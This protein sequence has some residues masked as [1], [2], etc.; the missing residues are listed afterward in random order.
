LHQATI[1]SEETGRLLSKIV[2]EEIEPVIQ[3]LSRALLQ[4]RGSRSELDTCLTK[5]E[6]ALN[7]MKTAQQALENSVGK[8]EEISERFPAH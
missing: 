7:R 2:G 8:L 4:T 1:V 3:E 6:T 5:F